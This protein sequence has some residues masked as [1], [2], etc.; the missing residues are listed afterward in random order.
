M[1]GGED[2][3]QFEEGG[4]ESS[5]LSDKSPTAQDFADIAEVCACV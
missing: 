4:E 5:F 2:Q 1:S 3:L